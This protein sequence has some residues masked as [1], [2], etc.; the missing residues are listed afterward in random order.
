MNRIKHSSVI[1]SV[2]IHKDKQVCYFLLFI[3]L[4]QFTKSIQ[5][6]LNLSSNIYIF[7]KYFLHFFEATEILKVR[8]S[9]II[10]TELILSASSVPILFIDVRMFTCSKDA[11]VLPRCQKIQSFF[12]FAHIPNFCLGAVYMVLRFFKRSLFAYARTSRRSVW[13]NFHLNKKTMTFNKKSTACNKRTNSCSV[14]SLSVLFLYASEYIMYKRKTIFVALTFSS[15][16]FRLS[17]KNQNNA[18]LQFLIYT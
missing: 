17:T 15:Y 3:D 2:S 4:M 1:P 16:Q 18:I 9:N 11:A 7:Y 12:V 6:H 5:I 14:Q 8:K 13:L 10:A